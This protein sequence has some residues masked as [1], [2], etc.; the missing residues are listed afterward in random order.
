[1]IQEIDLKTMKLVGNP[2]FIG[3]GAMLS[4]QYPEGPKLFKKD[5]FYYLVIAEGGTGQF[6][7]VTIS[8][9]KNILG[10]YESYE[11]NPILTHRSLAYTHPFINIGHADFVQAA[12]DEWW[13]VCLGSRPLGAKDNI[14]GR[15]TFLVPVK[16][17]KGEWPVISPGYGQVRQVE[18][19]PNLKNHQVASIPTRDDFDSTRLSYVWTFIRTPNANL[20]SLLEKKGSIKINLLPTQLNKVESP[21]FIGQRLRFRNGEMTTKATFKSKSKNEEAGMVI[22]KSE[23]AF[24]KFVLNNKQIKI[25]QQKDSLETTLYTAPLLSTT[26][27][28]KV[29]QRENKFTFSYRPEGGSWTTVLDSYDGRIFSVEQSGGFMGTFVG[30]YG[31]SQGAPSKNSVTFDYFEYKPLED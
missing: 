2:S 14:L 3:R 19:I 21:G 27:E 12:K 7:A 28:F 16:W 18:K 4:S 13:M 17:D 25:V 10:P 29:I 9:S 1:M 15:E 23:K 22:Y 11:G 31:S 8:R 26:S 5:N 6:H 24:V 30:V 20:Y